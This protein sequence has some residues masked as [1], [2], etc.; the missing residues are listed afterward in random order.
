MAPS[1]CVN[2]NKECVKWVETYF[3]DCLCNLRDDISFS[4]GLMSL[5][6]WGVAEIPQIITIF[7]TKSSHGVSLAFLLT[8]VAGK[9][10]LMQRHMQL[11]GLPPGTS[12]GECLCLIHIICS[13]ALKGGPYRDELALTLD[14]VA[15]VYLF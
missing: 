9:L 5:V 2:E 11:G 13:V 3:K 6:S 8:W 4:L 10:I 12:N 14:W 7:L 15:F 1:Y